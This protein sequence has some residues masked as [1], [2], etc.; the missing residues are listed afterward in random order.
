MVLLV[1][2]SNCPGEFLAVPNDAKLLTIYYPDIGTPENK[3]QFESEMKDLY[4]LRE[5][6]VFS[7]PP[8][9]QF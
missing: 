2:L 4:G 3:M 8:E 5:S 1:T 7:D 9:S 6:V